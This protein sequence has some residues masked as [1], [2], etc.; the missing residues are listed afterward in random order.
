MCHESYTK[1]PEGLNEYR[2]FPLN[3]VGTDPATALNFERLVLPVGASEAQ[4]FGAAAF[5]I[6]RN[7]LQKSYESKGITD[8]VR[9]RWE[10]R[11]LR[12]QPEFRSTLRQSESF[13]DSR[14]LKVYRSKTLR[15]IWATAPYLHNGS[16][17]T[18]YDLL[19]PAAQRPKKFT[20][21]TREYDPVKLGYAENGPVAA[22]LQQTT[23]DTSLPG[24]WNTGHEWWFYPSL[25]E[26]DRFNLIEF[27]KTFWLPNDQDYEFDA[28]ST[29]PAEVRAPY[30]LEPPPPVQQ[31]RP[32]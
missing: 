12:P 5:N 26:A 8:E 16:V 15:G 28:P 30:A 21:G 20:V 25:T 4:P 29:M 10:H 18:I 1:T 14:G 32:Q 27:L 23:I 3:V 13:S 24:N 31:Y 9:A 19:L 11:S 6:V 2:L 17:P 7:V 22:G